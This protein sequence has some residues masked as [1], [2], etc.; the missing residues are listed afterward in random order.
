LARGLFSSIG[1]L[2]VR[3]LIS[4]GATTALGLSYL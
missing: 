3:D 2:D 4:L 1:K